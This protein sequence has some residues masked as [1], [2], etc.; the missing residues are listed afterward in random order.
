M[1]TSH[2]FS[3]D[4]HF[5]PDESPPRTSD[6]SRHRKAR[7]VAVALIGV[8]AA[9]LATQNIVLTTIQGS[10]RS[11]CEANLKR[12]GRA[13]HE[14]LEAHGHFPAPA[15]AR[16]DGTPLLSWR[17]ALLPHLGYQPLYARFHLDEPWDSPHNRSLLAEMPPELACP[18][19]AVPRDG[20]TGYKVVI[21]PSSARLVSI[22][23][24]TPRAERRSREIT[25][26]TSN[27]VLVMETDALV[28]W[29][30]PDDLHWQ[31]GGPPP[32][33]QEPPFRRDTGGYC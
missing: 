8:P 30:K 1:D 27:T 11:H 13:F 7:W 33:T 9:I 2:S 5:I 23:R 31:P 26:G 22:P 17:V 20:Q 18:A 3:E 28:P 29:T 32:Q 6:R 15:I 4:V 19:V 21:G 24:L 14:Y 12:L 25:D 16:S 10:R